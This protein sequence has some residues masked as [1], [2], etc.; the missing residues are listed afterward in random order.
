MLCLQP[1]LWAVNEVWD[2]LFSR[3]AHL[4]LAGRGRTKVQQGSSAAGTCEPAGPASARSGC[5]RSCN[6][7]VP[8]RGGCELA[9]AD[10]TPSAQAHQLTLEVSLLDSVSLQDLYLPHLAHFVYQNGDNSTTGYGTSNNTCGESMVYLTFII[11]YYHLLPEEIVFAHAH[12]LVHTYWVVI[13]NS[14][15]AQPRS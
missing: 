10:F 5:S 13:I 11:D 4:R 7:A 1:R 12:R 3:P 15:W 9:G 8:R 6:S 2:V 14:R